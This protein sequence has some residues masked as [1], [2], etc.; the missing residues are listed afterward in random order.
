MQNFRLLEAVGKTGKP[1]GLKR[2][3]S[4]TIQEWLNAAE[5][6]AVQGF[7]HHLCYHFQVMSVSGFTHDLQAFFT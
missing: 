7:I 6:I 4:G 3:I 1:I 5:Y 2:G